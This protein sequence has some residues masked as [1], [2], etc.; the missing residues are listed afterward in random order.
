MRA[1][2]VRQTVEAWNTAGDDARYDDVAGPLGIGRSTFATR[3]LRGRQMGLEVRPSPF[4]KGPRAAPHKREDV[5]DQWDTW[6][7]DGATV[8]EAA[9]ALG[10]KLDTFQT[11]LRRARQRGDDRGR[12]NVMRRRTPRKH[13]RPK[14]DAYLKAWNEA[15]VDSTVTEV[16]KAIG[17]NRESLAHI[18]HRARREGLE[19]RESGYRKRG[20][21]DP[22][23]VEEWEHL[24]SS[25]VHITEAA[26]RLNVTEDTL[27]RIS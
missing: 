22:Y 26:R 4:T 2:V 23:V 20:Q 27:R 17:T 19:V 11:I 6:R 21:V 7:G 16:A 24:R 25:G 12:Y 1:D 5:L 13:R 18:L 14:F 15:A 8:E 9:Q 3:L 10:M